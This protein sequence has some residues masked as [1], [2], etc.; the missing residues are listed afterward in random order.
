MAVYKIL[1]YPHVLLRKKSTPVE[2]FTSD[3]KVFADGMIST[4]NAFEGIG[5]AAPQVGILKRVIVMDITPY[6][7]NP[8]V[9]DWHGKIAVKVNDKSVPL[10]FPLTLVNPEIVQ[11]EG[12][13]D[14]PF[15]GCLSFPGVDR[16]QTKRAK[17]VKL[18]ALDAEQNKITIECDGIMSICIQHEID[19]LE[20][21]LFIDRLRETAPSEKVIVEEIKEY[22]SESSYKK[23]LKKLNPVDARDSNFQFV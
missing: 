4:M 15:D 14:F 11:R 12:E 17:F 3:L 7:E 13:T 2:K 20:G 9:A 23:A 6:L 5:L 10:K 1:K 19:H 16:G 18:E 8:D 22:E 21:V